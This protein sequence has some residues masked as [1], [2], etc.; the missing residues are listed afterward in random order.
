MTV[1]THVMSQTVAGFLSAQDQVSATL[2]ATSDTVVDVQVYLSSS[3]GNAP[4]PV[5]VAGGFKVIDP[6]TGNLVNYE[7]TVVQNTAD[8]AQPLAWN[9]R[10]VFAPQASAPSV[11]VR[12]TA[13]FMCFTAMP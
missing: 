5:A 7:S 10:I 12:V 2:S 6:T 3:S 8:P 4:N 13:T 9:V 11:L 1:S